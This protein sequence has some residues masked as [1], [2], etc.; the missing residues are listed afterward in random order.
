M[1]SLA[2][3][4][5]IVQ[6]SFTHFTSVINNELKQDFYLINS[7]HLLDYTLSLLYLSVTYLSYFAKSPM[8]FGLGTA[9]PNQT[10]ASVGFRH[11]EL[12]LHFESFVIQSESGGF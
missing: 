12:K 8:S 1:T 10:L 4:T 5:T 11:Q 7:N 2:E 9:Q 3:A 6:L